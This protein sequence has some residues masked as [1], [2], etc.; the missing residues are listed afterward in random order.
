ME[1]RSSEIGGPREG[2]V[3]LAWRPIGFAFR[4]DPDICET[5]EVAKGALS[6][7][8]EGRES[9]SQLCANIMVQSAQLSAAFSRY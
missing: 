7:Q 3:P 1:H 9:S 6:M 5:R 8:P 2:A 4:R